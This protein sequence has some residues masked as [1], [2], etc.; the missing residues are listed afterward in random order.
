[1]RSRFFGYALASAGAVGGALYMN[2]HL[3]NAMGFLIGFA[4]GSAFAAGTAIASRAAN[5]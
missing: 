1:M 3:P 2:T 4:A 5:K